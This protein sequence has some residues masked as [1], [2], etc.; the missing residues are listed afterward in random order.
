MSSRI[1]AFTVGALV[2]CLGCP[3]PPQVPDGGK[4]DGGPTTGL[5]PCTGGCGPLQIC[6]E[7][8]H[9]CEDGCGG[10]D[11]GVCTKNA[12]GQFQCVPQTTSCNGTQ[13]AQGQAACV[14]GSCSCL[15]FTRA[16]RDSCAA[17][18]QVCR[19][20]F[21]PVTSSG[22]ACDSPQLYE[23]CKTQGCPSGNCASCAAGLICK[24][25]FCLRPCT[26]DAQC[27]RDEW[28]DTQSGACWPQSFFVRP[29]CAQ[30]FANPDGGSE[31][32]IGAVPVS[33]TCLLPT[34]V[35]RPGQNPTV[36]YEPGDAGTGNCTYSFFRFSN[37]LYTAA[38]C[39]PPGTAARNAAC[40]R[41]WSTG[42]Q[43]LQCGTGLEC[44]FAAGGDGLCLRAC[45]ATD[46]RG[47]VT[48]QPACGTDESCV[49]L[50]RLEDT[51][52]VVGVCLK[53]C[54]VFS[55]TLGTCA[56]YGAVKASCVPTPADGRALVTADGSGVCIPQKPT[57]AAAGQKCAEVDSL[58]GA[59]CGSALVCMASNLSELPACERPC[60]V[61]CGLTP[62][63][64]RCS[65]EPNARCLDGKSCTRVTST[66]GA[67]L[68][69]C[70]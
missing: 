57:V 21:N 16:S 54:D 51:N 64:A 67:I 69:F 30:R 13:C 47:G 42:T 28:C 43:A 63:P 12:A 36:V 15:P 9:Q 37:F 34:L 60:D 11:A 14:A 59:A 35:Q 61:E 25:G 49:N 38:N 26:A 68:G 40:K 7:E 17:E 70:R 3:P 24:Q 53:K 45:N 44:G 39:K 55:A 33:N 41:D 8:K 32:I 46:P 66:S 50:Y 29:D 23:E 62:A 65:T 56:D 52:A 18:G 10:C 22:G 4:E 27:N 2:V 5:G 19:E 1:L 20:M 6:N 31:N 58:K 48:P